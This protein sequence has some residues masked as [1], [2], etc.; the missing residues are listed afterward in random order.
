MNI[1]FS[2]VT[3]F[4]L[5][6]YTTSVNRIVLI[7]CFLD[8]QCDKKCCWVMVL[9]SFF[10]VLSPTWIYSDV[11][12]ICSLL[13]IIEQIITSTQ[14]PFSISLSFSHTHTHTCTHK[15]KSQMRQFPSE[16][17]KLSNEN[18]T[19][20]KS[21]LAK[22]LKIVLSYT[23]YI[24][25]SPDFLTFKIRISGVHQASAAEIVE[26]VIRVRVL[27]CSIFRPAFV[28]CAPQMLVEI[29]IFSIFCAKKL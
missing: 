24:Q 11:V 26:T 20:Y 13:P 18:N 10:Y 8:R 12:R 14:T 4:C 17:P 9:Y 1:R 22:S 23:R 6:L 27:I 29:L 28:C 2:Y 3:A 15:N 5:F 7:N 21:C 25:F 19:K 16:R